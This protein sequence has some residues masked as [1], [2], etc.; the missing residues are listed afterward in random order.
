M[1]KHYTVGTVR[2]SVIV[3]RSAM[4]SP[5]GVP[6]SAGAVKIIV[7][8][9]FLEIIKTAFAFNGDKFAVFVDKDTGRVVSAVFKARGNG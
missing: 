2:M 6:H 7:F 9:S 8:K 3:G 1:Y 5:T 4:C